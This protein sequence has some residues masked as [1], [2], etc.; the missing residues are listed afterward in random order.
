MLSA[1]A[2]SPHATIPA[3]APCVAPSPKWMSSES[4]VP[5]PLIS[6]VNVTGV[7]AAAFA[8][9]TVTVTVSEPVSAGR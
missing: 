4:R 8:G 7:P 1:R 5:G 9:L 3:F 6:T 2:V